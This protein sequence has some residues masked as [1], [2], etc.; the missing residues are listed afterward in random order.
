MDDVEPVERGERVGAVRGAAFLFFE[1]LIFFCV[2]SFFFVLSERKKIRSS[3]EI[4]S[5]FRALLSSRTLRNQ[6]LTNAQVTSDA[7]EDQCLTHS[8]TRRSPARRGGAGCCCILFFV[9]LPTPI[10]RLA[11]S[12]RERICARPL[13]ER[14]QLG[15]VEP[16]SANR[17][18]ERGGK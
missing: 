7:S 6:F 12:S 17:L 1:V 14:Q 4:L 13:R 16:W 5:L 9:F 8:A 15:L 3:V 10:L 18:E 11:A 2:E